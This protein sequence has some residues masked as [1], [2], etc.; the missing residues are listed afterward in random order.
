MNADQPPVFGIDLGTTNSCVAS[1]S[2]GSGAEVIPN[3]DSELLTPSVV[4]F[5]SPDN[6]IVG[7]IAKSYAI[8]RPELVCSHVKREMSKEPQQVKKLVYHDV[9]YSPEQVSAL[10]L[11][12]VIADALD[13]QALPRDSRV[14]AVIT[15]PAYFGTIGKNAT[16][17]AGKLANIDVLYVAPEPVAAAVAYGSGRQK[18]TERPLDSHRLSTLL[19]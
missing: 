10:I 1:L 11:R 18:E 13:K 9:S 8:A 12:K 6:I 19:T 14:P 3:A 7:K 2:R 16:L 5:E 4:F 17:Q 15:V